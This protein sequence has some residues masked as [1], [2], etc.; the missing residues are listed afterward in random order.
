MRHTGMVREPCG[1]WA[2]MPLTSICAGSRSRWRVWA[3]RRHPIV[4]AAA[5]GRCSLAS[6]A[7]GPMRSDAARG[8]ETCYLFRAPSENIAQNRVGIFPKQ[9]CCAPVAHRCAR[10]ADGVRGTWD[11]PAS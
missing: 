7:A 2:A 5:A 3:G 6:G 11:A 10:Q 4:K 1:V 9:W 8:A